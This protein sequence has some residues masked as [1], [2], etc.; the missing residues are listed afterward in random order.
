MTRSA[1]GFSLVELVVAMSVT[2]VITSAVFGLS[3]VGRRAFDVQTQ[4]ADAQQRLRVGLETLARDLQSARL[5]LPYRVPGPA[6]DPPGTFRDDVVTIVLPDPEGGADLVR[7]YYV[8]NT[9]PDAGAQLMRAAGMGRDAPVIDHFGA[10]TLLYFGE[11]GAGADPCA[12]GPPAGQLVALGRNELTDGPWCTD[13]S[14]PDAFD[15][16]LLRIRRVD[17][18]L[19]GG[20]ARTAA[21]PRNLNL[22]R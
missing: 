22:E 13:A 19:G 11:P 12:L 1:S 21:A 4:S 10:L 9:D 6:G 17:V 2:L 15:A 3:T 16:D 5:V 8:R 18:H 20:A 7:A 14:V